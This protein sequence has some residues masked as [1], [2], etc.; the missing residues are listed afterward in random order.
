MAGTPLSILSIARI[1]LEGM[2]VLLDATGDGETA[3]CPSCG[4]DCRR[5]HDR[6]QRWPLDVPWRGFVVRLVVTVRRFCCDNRACPRQ[7]FAEEF[8]VVLARRAR[9]T[10]DVRGYL[11]ELAEAVGGRAGARLAQRQGAPASRFT[12]L[13]LVRSEPVPDLPTPRVLGVDDLALRR[14]RHYATLLV[15]METHEPI[16]LLEGREAE[17]L[18]TW[19]RAH[20]GVEI[21]VRDRGGAYAEGAR[22]GA[23]DARQIADRFHLV[24]NVTDALD[25]LAKRRPGE[26]PTEDSVD[27]DAPPPPSVVG[28]GGAELPAA[29][30]VTEEPASR[31]E[32]PAE[33]ALL[34]PTKQRQAQRRE[35]RDARWQRVHDLHQ[36]GGSLRGIARDLG[37]N[38]TTVR[39]LLATPAPPRNRVI[40]PRPGGITSPMLAPF[41]DYL[42]QRWRAGCTNGCQLYRE[43][44]DRGYTGSRTLVLE[45]IR[46]WRPAKP[47]KTLRHRANQRRSDP[48]RL[49]RLLGR[50]PEKLTADEWVAVQ[51]VL[52]RDP[53]LAKGYVLTQRFRTLLQEHDLAAFQTWLADAKASTLPSFVGLANGML[54]DR[55]AIAA[56]ITEPWSNGIVEGHVHKVK[57][58]K[59][60][61][62]GRAKLDLLRRRVRTA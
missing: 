56:A 28:P 46:S 25:E 40:H 16:D 37:I 50:P 49:R 10:A 43:L 27:G 7:T 52:D 47:P 54:A 13:R 34:S 15:N 32:P 1:R 24:C 26:T 18:A 62:Y 44:V 36:Q 4:A 39:R 11:R 14:G 3:A 5:I 8:G 12:L 60:Q 53:V 58:I 38:K 48:R 61:G 57:L 41:T 45:A 51:Q 42:Q 9:F 22:Q 30:P 33:L 2:T 6:Y 35:A 59:R 20:P 23:P 55:S 19:L 21:I 29:E 31:E 17:V